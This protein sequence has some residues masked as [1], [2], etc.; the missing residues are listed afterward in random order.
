MRDERGWAGESGRR[1]RRRGHRD[2]DGGQA[3]ALDAP[4]RPGAP[5]RAG[6]VNFQ[7]HA[8]Y[9]WVQQG[10]GQFWMVTF[11]GDSDIFFGIT[12]AGKGESVNYIQSRREG[13]F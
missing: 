10:E 5:T 12:A 2:M 1:R 6:G 11:S 4:G 9:D 7:F 8:R 13:G 3:K